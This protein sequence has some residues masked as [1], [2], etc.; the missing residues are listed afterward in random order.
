MQVAV[1]SRLL[2]Y[3]LCRDP[4][5]ELLRNPTSFNPRVGLLIPFIAM[6]R[7]GSAKLHRIYIAAKAHQDLRSHHR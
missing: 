2:Y 5:A 7:Q 1:A 4:K 6:R 3:L